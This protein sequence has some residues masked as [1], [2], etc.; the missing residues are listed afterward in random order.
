MI[1]LDLNSDALFE[2]RRICEAEG[3]NVRTMTCDVGSD[4]DVEN[5]FHSLQSNERRIDI[6]VN[7][8][9]ICGS[10]PIF[11]DNFSS[12]WQD[13]NINFG[14]VGNSTSWPRT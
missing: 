1:L 8:A 5:V 2:T 13:M 10:N 9:G 7:C 6:L 4:E 12:M 14:G 3:S 11:Y